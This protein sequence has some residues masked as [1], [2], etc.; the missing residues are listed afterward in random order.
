MN[1][2]T[3]KRGAGENSVGSSTSRTLSCSTPVPA[4]FFTVALRNVLAEVGTPQRTRARAKKS[5]SV[6]G[7]LFR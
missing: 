3:L 7:L 6:V 5:F 2:A 1:A 4:D